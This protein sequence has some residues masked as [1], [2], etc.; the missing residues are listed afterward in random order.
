MVP[1]LSKLE[2]LRNIFGLWDDEPFTCSLYQNML[3]SEGCAQGE[4]S[5]SCQL[6]PQAPERLS[7]A[8]SKRGLPFLGHYGIRMR[9]LDRE[10]L[11]SRSDAW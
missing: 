4:D 1:R 3:R 11:E 6:F 2:I 8:Q 5:V 7:K 9:R 10:I